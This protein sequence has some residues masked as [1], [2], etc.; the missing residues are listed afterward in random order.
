[1][2]ELLTTAR[3]YAKAL[4]KTAREQNMIDA[5]FDMLKNLLT[6]V[7][8]K[9]VS[10]IL[11]NDSYDSKYKSSL[12]TDILKDSSN[13]HFNRFINLLIDNARIDVVHEIAGLY[14]I[15]LQEEKSQKTALIDTAFELD[16]DQITEIKKA[17]EKRFDKKI[18]I[19]QNIDSTLLAGAVVKVDDLVIDG[20]YKEQL[21]KLESH[22]I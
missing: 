12:I 16:S 13:D 3:P 18:E 7:S 2:S 20:S 21:R 9:N 15:F 8:D 14:D 17:L 10:K 4:F 11:S 19:K 6:V 1:M 5:Y 22:L